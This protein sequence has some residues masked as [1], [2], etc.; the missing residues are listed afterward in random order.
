MSR[1]DSVI[2]VLRLHD[3]IVRL[4]SGKI[5]MSESKLPQGQNEKILIDF[6]WGLWSVHIPN[7]LIVI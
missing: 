3:K 6:R 2:E 4:I 5:A 7:Y 1:N